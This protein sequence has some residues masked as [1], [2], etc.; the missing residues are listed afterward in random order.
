[1]HMITVDEYVRYRAEG[2]LIVPG[3]V[4][5]E[6]V[7]ELLAHVE[8]GPGGFERRPYAASRA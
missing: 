5:P 8:A 7:A 1:M 6:E 3:L 4:A 2:H